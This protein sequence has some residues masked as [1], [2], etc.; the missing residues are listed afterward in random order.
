MFLLFVSWFESDFLK[1]KTFLCVP[2]SDI[3]IFSLPRS[4]HVKRSPNCGFLTMKKDFTELTVAEFYHME[5]E[6]LKVYHVSVPTIC[7]DCVQWSEVLLKC[8][9]RGCFTFC[10]FPFQRKVCHKKMAY[11]R[12]DIDHTLETLKSQLDSLW[13]KW[14]FLILLSH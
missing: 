4:E 7:V 10:F 3:V 11:L 12:D 14:K 13:V 2:H 9:C 1:D 8:L 6:R 5:K